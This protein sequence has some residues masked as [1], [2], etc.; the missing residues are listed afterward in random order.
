VGP[1]LGSFLASFFYFILEAFRWETANPGQDDDD[2]EAQ[3]L[4]TSRKTPQ[5]G[6]RD[7]DN[8]TLKG[9]A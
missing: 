8:S 9:D 6:S 2:L 5:P 4:D 3:A 7:N 1:A